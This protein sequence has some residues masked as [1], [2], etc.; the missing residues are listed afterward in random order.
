MRLEIE[1]SEDSPRLSGVCHRCGW[2]GAVSKVSRKARRVL[3]SDQKYGRLCDECISDLERSARAHPAT[4]SEST[5]L[6]AVR[7]RNVA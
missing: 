6:R 2:D 5:T 1:R 4:T 7:D 3:N